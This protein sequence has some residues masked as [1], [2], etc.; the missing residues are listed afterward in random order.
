M[1]NRLLL[2]A[3]LTHDYILVIGN[4]DRASSMRHFIWVYTICLDKN[5]F[6]RNTIFIQ[7]LYHVTLDIIYSQKEESISECRK[8]TKYETYVNV[9]S[10]I[11][12]L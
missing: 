8:C 9:F 12:H 2:I 4:L 6:R 10:M 7:K 3:T 11:L 1:A 5:D